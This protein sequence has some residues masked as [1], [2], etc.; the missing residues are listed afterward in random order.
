[1]LRKAGKISQAAPNTPWSLTVS[2]KT[3]AAKQAPPTAQQEVLKGIVAEAVEIEEKP[4]TWKWDTRTPRMS[5]PRPPKH[6]FLNEKH[7]TPTPPTPKPKINREWSAQLLAALP[8]TSAELFKK[9]GKDCTPSLSRLKANGRVYNESNG[10]LWKRGQPKALP[11]PKRREPP[12]HHPKPKRVWLSRDVL[13]FLAL[14][15]Q[16]MAVLRKKF[17]PHSSPMMSRLKRE[18]LAVN[19]GY[20]SP[21]RVTRAGALK[22]G[23]EIQKDPQMTQVEQILKALVRGPATTNDLANRLGFNKGTIGTA[24]S[25]LRVQRKVDQDFSGGPWRLVNGHSGGG[26]S[27]KKA[28]GPNEAALKKALGGQDPDIQMLLERRAYHMRK[29]AALDAAIQALIEE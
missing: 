6:F 11:Q 28:M 15:P 26:A 5:Q 29:G 10:G 27:P 9:F 7:Q 25:G 17:G 1:M 24:L 16:P 19:A 18:G 4:P 12:R 23:V 22:V 8:A 3:K 14:G 2:K 20:R 21:W 13:Q